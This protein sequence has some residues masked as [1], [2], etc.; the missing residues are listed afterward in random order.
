MNEVKFKQTFVASDEATGERR[1]VWSGLTQLESGATV[2][3]WKQETWTKADL[4]GERTLQDEHYWTRE[5]L[6]FDTLELCLANA[7][8]PIETN[9]P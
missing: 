1:K 6:V 3:V 4:N 2:R 8:E 9:E 7:I 5:G